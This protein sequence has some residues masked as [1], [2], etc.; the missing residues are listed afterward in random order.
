MEDIKKFDS[1]KFWYDGFMKGG[2]ILDIN[3][4]EKGMICYVEDTRTH[5]MF[6]ISPTQLTKE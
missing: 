1:I 2:K 4:T 3:L 6:S 5:E